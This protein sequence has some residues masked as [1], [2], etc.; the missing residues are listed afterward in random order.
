MGYL[1]PQR[2]DTALLL[3]V[4]ELVSYFNSTNEQVIA[5]HLQLVANDVLAKTGD[6]TSALNSSLE[7]LNR[8][9][10]KNDKFGMVPAMQE[11]STA[12]YF[13]GDREMNH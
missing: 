12:Y 3:K 13:A 7:I 2:S 10:K 4:Q 1:N 11:V 9:E 5:D 6:Y 8:F